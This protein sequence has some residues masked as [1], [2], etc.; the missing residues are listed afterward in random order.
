MRGKRGSLL[1]ASGLLLILG[2]FVLS[3][4]N[5]YDDYRAQSAL[6]ET[7]DTLLVLVEDERPAELK[8]PPPQAADAPGFAHQE[9]QQ[10]LPVIEA[11]EETVSELVQEIAAAVPVLSGA[12]DT[13]VPP[14]S[15]ATPVPVAASAAPA[16]PVAV[17]QADPIAAP[18]PTVADPAQTAAVT[19][20]P[21]AVPQ[22]EAQPSF[23]PQQLPPDPMA[24]GAV[25]TEI[26]IPDFILNPQM[27]MPVL[28]NGGYEYIGVLSI[29]GLGLELPI[30]DDWDY[31]RLK[32]APCRF[33]GSAYTNNLV[34]AAHNYKAHFGSL[35]ELDMGSRVIFTDADGNEF[36]YAVVLC[37]TLK[38][39]HVLEM[40]DSEFGLTLFTC[41]LGGA[42][43]VT[44]RCELIGGDWRDYEG[45]L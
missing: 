31:K 25:E 42:N 35:K 3:G 15:T 34:I 43:R 37:E 28:R 14:M 5:L 2:A 7:M 33:T 23:A 44:L 10:A 30:M 24:G 41:T 18:V 39:G 20:M 13:P 16:Q 38:P 4:Y 9:E 29:P 12:T 40:A 36:I 8:N 11:I 45:M 19:I 27:P 21:T 26:E 6:Q 32:I 22:Q 1:I 17:I